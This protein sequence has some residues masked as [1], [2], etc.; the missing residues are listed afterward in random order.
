MKKGSGFLAALFLSATLLFT[1]TIVAVSGKAEAS[2]E[3][4]AV[5]AAAV[6]LHSQKA[7]A[8]DAAHGPADSV[9]PA[10]PDVIP[11]VS[12]E[13]FFS[14][15][16]DGVGKLIKEVGSKE[17][18]AKV[19]AIALVLLQLFYKLLGTPLFASVWSKLKPNVRFIV[20]AVTSF[21]TFLLTQ[22]SMGISFGAAALSSVALIAL[23]DYV[24][25]YYERF[26]EKK[27][28]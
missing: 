10:D 3:T 6:L 16:V 15:L 1:G 24:R 19:I 13:S 26:I 11:A 21:A 14:S 20:V 5:K 17:G 12:N 4:Q 27:A 28:A 25:K 7:V 22:L 8:Q 18:W 2:T 23:V 9:L